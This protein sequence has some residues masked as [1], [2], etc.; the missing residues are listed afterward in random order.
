MQLDS[1]HHISRASQLLVL[2]RILPCLHRRPELLEF[3]LLHLDVNRDLSLKLQ[4]LCF[5]HALVP[6]TNHGRELLDIQL[7]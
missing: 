7:L 5:L 1:S 2:Y 3:Q 6:R 4:L